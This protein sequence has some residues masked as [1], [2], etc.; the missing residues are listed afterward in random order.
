[1]SFRQTYQLN[2]KQVQKLVL[3]QTM[4]QSLQ[5]L[6]A[7]VLDLND[8]VKEQSLENPLFDV[9]PRLSKTE[10]ALS[11]QT[12]HVDVAPQNLDD[13]L[14][15]QVQLTMRKTH[16]QQIVILLINCLDE[17]GYLSFSQ[18]QLQR[19]L[20]IQPLE[21]ADA[22]ELLVNLDPP[23]VGAQSL[24]ECL[25]LQLFNLPAT[26]TN[27]LASQMLKQTFDQV[28]SHDWAAITTQLQ[29]SLPQVQAAFGVIQTLSPYP[30]TADQ[31]AQYVIPELIVQRQGQQLS[32][33]VTKYGYP[34]LIFVQETYDMLKQSTDRAVQQYVQQK[35]QAYQTLQQNL[36]HRLT[37]LS[38][39]GQ[40]I[41]EVQADFFLN[42]TASLHPLLLRDLAQKLALSESTVSRALNGKYLQ[43]ERGIFPL[44][45]FLMKRSSGPADHSVAEVQTQIK[46]LVQ[47]EDK[48]HP[49]SD[50][51]LCA[52]LT[53]AGDYISRRT[54]AKYR[55]QLGIVAAA[56]RKV[57]R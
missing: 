30:Y 46:T 8:Y 14:L 37:T 34:N 9:N 49:L 1:M 12:W 50:Q 43:C 17:H 53:Q 25:Q 27:L 48:A 33:E 35:Y 2:Q 19:E 52:L 36:N 26:P 5:I 55:Q 56:K 13:Y 3:S 20:Q 11:A 41:I 29:V 42:D 6:Q 18:Q 40:L 24:Q 22:K 16:L 54:V 51:K 21:F 4:K 57:R 47:Q 38:L 32:L 39:I 15:E 10:V 44:K 23:G 28:V 31:T 7:N 45:S